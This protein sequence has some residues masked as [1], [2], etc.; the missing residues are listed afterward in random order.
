MNQPSRLIAAIF[1]VALLGACSPPSTNSASAT[2]N[3][4]SNQPL[5]AG[6]APGGGGGG[7]GAVRQ[8]CAADVQQYCPGYVWGAPGSM[9]ACSHAHFN[10]FSQPCQ[11][12]IVAARNRWQGA[13]SGRNQSAPPATNSP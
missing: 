4:A 1:A 8:A 2:T 12:A 7:G 11:A 10:E 3:A 6:V 5:S 13:E 9:Y